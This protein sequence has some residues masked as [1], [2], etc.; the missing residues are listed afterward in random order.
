M[1]AMCA[2]KSEFAKRIIC[3]SEPL[4]RWKEIAGIKKEST[5]R[6]KSSCNFHIF[7]QTE[8][9]VEA[10]HFKNL[11]RVLQKSGQRLN[12]RVL[13]Q[14][15]MK[16][17]YFDHLEQDLKKSKDNL[18]GFEKVKFSLINIHTFFLQECCFSGSS[19]EF[20]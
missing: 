3:Q 11:S 14:T 1:S 19:S 20:L 16:V 13:K 9:F 17:A 8:K 7:E 6:K 4:E 18:Q 2:K 10:Q 5:G 15:V 12:P